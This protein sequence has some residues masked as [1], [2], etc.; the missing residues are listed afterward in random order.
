MGQAP[1][2]GAA[3]LFGYPGHNSTNTEDHMTDSTKAVEPPHARFKLGALAATPGALAALQELGVEPMEL[4]VRHARGDFGELNAEDR[5]SNEVAIAHGLR[6]LSAY[7][8][9]APSD[10]AKEHRIW[11][12]TEADRSVTTVLTPSEY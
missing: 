8:V 9:H 6:I 4:L 7:T 11:V 3:A 5:A 2:N 12:I 1:H 10:T